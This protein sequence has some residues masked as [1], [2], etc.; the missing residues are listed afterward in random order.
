MTAF[1]DITPDKKVMEKIYRHNKITRAVWLTIIA[2]VVLG[3]VF[4]V[5]INFDVYLFTTTHPSD[6]RAEIQLDKYATQ[7]GNSVSSNIK[8]NAHSFGS[9]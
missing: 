1:T 5:S 8:D 2:V 3:I 9:K 6:V 7:Q 4:W